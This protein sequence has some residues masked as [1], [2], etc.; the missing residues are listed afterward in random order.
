MKKYLFLYL[1]LMLYSVS[2]I[3]SKLAGAQ[4]FLS[5]SFIAL[6]GTVLGI[7]LIYAF[8]WQKILRF[9]PLTTAFSNKAIIIPFGMIWGAV[10]FKE[11]ITF[12]M[13]LG[14]F[15][16]ISGVLIIGSESRE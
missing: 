7:L 11:A 5:L 1:T 13:I 6:Y 14:A 16:I 2:G 12:Q 4:D 9:F 8:L 10:F 3:F 15:V